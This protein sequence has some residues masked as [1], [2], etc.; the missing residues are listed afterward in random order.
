MQSGFRSVRTAL[1]LFVLFWASAQA[2]G[3]TDALVSVDHQEITAAD[4][5]RAMRS[6]PF[7]TNFN[8]L[9]KKEQA[10]LRGG[11]LQ[12]LVASRLLLLEAQNQGLDKTKGFQEDLERFRIGLLH[13]AYI[14]HLRT[15]IELPEETRKQM[16]AQ[17]KGNH[18]AYKAAQSAYINGEY[19]KARIQ[20]I[21]DLRKRYHVQVHEDRMTPGIAPE[22]VLVEGD[23]FQVA[24]SDLLSIP[25]RHE[26]KE[27]IE[28]HAFSRAELLMTAKAAVDNGIDVSAALDSYKTERMP[29]LLMEKLEAQWIPS[30]QPLKAYFQ[31]HPEY[32]QLLSR[33][34]IG[35]LVVATR[36]EAEDMRKRIVQGESLFRLAGEYSIDPYGRQ[37]KGDMGWIK[38]DHGNPK[39]KAA[40]ANLEDNEVSQIVET[41]LGFH[42]VTILE[43]KPGETKPFGVVRDKVRQ[44]YL[45]EMLTGYL[46]NL[47]KKYQ[48]VWHIPTEPQKQN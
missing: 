46:K 19:K 28:D 48:V 23:G 30:D 27:W 47:E 4:L 9:D 37:H 31:M 43:R 22:T 35:Q 20:S 12:R 42:L 10:F 11:L 13:R 32:G 39:I 17:F 45:S 7:A 5:E 26:T 14:S 44:A 36:A 3:S 29:A 16:K 6:S 21:R 40:I 15:S 1:L 24:Y 8:T 34:H 25:D 2:A 38:E 41:P 33:R 18:E